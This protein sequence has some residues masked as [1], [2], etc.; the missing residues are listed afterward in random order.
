MHKSILTVFRLFFAAVIFIVTLSLFVTCFAKFY[1]ILQADE[2][3]AQAQH[4]SLISNEKE[5]F[6]L[7]SNNQKPDNA[8]Y[9]LIAGNGYVAKVSCDHYAKL[10]SDDDN[11]SHTRQIQSINLFKAGQHTYIKNVSY[12]D[13]R[14]AQKSQLEFSPNEIE[15]FYKNDISNLKYVI[16]GVGLFALAALYVSVKILKNFRRFIGK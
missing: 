9:V 15:Q 16:F 7:V 13:S 14:T 11:T 3:Y 12:T 1:E 5:Q 8:I 6:V 10:C 4:I 2:N